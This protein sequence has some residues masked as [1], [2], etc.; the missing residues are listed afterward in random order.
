MDRIA[1]LKEVL[2]ENPND[3]FARYGLAMEYSKAGDVAGAL[4][5]FNTIIQ[6]TPDYVPAYQ[7]AGQMLMSAGRLEQARKM[8]EDGIACALR[9]NNQ[10]AASEMQGFL[11]VMPS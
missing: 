11:D 7:M 9:T 5:E 6:H 3:A 2:A 10:H 1:S 8:F 4:A